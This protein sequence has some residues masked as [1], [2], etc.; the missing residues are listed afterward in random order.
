MKVF[1][2]SLIILFHVIMLSV[3]ISCND[4][5]DDD[6]EGVD[7][8]TNGGTVRNMIVVISD[9]HLGQDLSYAECNHNLQYLKN[10]LL[11]L[12]ESPNVKE[13]VIAGD[14]LDEWFIPAPINTYG[15]GDQS[16]FVQRIAQANEGVIN[17]LKSIINENKILVTYVP[18]N[19]DL[20]VTEANISLILPGINQARDQELGL[21]TYSPIGYPKIAIEHGHRYNFFCSPDPFSNQDIAPGTITP[22][23]YFFTRIGALHVA[24]GYPTV[25]G[26]TLSAITQ[27]PSANESQTLLYKYRRL[28]EWAIGY[29][30]INNKFDEDIIVTNFDGFTETYSV[31]DLVPFQTIP[32]GEIDVNLFKGI[33]DNWYQ[34]QIHNRVQ[35]PVPTAEAIENTA[36]ES[37]LSDRSKDQY[38]LNPNSD[39]RLVV[40]GHTH[41]AKIE[42][43]LNHTGQKA[44]YANTGTWIDHNSLASTNMEFVV[45]TPQSDDAT[46]QTSVKLYNYNG[47]KATLM[48]SDSLRF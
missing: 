6:Y 11:R 39:V 33:Q 36:K 2:R 47:G 17:A 8:F 22:P 25:A 48:T 38:F 3:L 10:F 35:V 19:H 20:T 23:G 14:L 4:S 9:I 27:N 40:F 37:E 26:D 13:L 15:N 5:S 41:V 43:S 16:D 44:I 24:Q 46:S 29:L 21:G 7:P 30:K 28:W 45:I 32:G 18:G 31:N 12:K 42:A 1:K 34:R